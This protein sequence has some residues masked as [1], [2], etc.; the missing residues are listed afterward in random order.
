MEISYVQP[1]NQGYAGMKSILLRPFDLGKWFALGFSAWLANLINGWGGGGG[2][3]WRAAFDKD[4]LR[5]VV[6]G[7]TD[8]V[9]SFFD[10]GVEIALLGAGLFVVLGIV[11]LFLW[12]SSRGHFVYLDNLVHN[13]SRV[14]EPWERLG[15]LADSLFRWRLV[16]TFVLLLGFG[17]LAAAAGLLSVALG[18][19]GWSRAVSVLGYLTLGST[20]FIAMIGVAYVHFFLI[21]YVVPLM[22]KHGEN[23]TAAWRRFLRQF[24]DEPWPFVLVGLFYLA[25]MLLVGVVIAAFGLATCCVGFILLGL[26]YLG[27]VVLLPVTTTLRLFDL[28]WLA[29]FGADF[30][31]RETN[32]LP[33]EA[34]PPA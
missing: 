29:Q 18:T 30:D 26:P 22:Y 23:A 5:E 7:T 13:R 34:P 8:R 14:T 12:L 31:A 21:H 1:L 9:E 3:N 24:S 32:A 15:G 2:S 28:N 17:T 20:A 25:I 33:V 10:H 19:G 4:D 11:V 27:A 6:T 16:F